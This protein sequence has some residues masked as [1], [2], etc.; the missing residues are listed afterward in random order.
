M[1]DIVK[2]S[3]KFHVN[4]TTYR[5]PALQKI[6]AYSEELSIG[7]PLSPVSDSNSTPLRVQTPNGNTKA[8][9]EYFPIR[10]HLIEDFAGGRFIDSTRDKFIDTFP[11]P[12]NANVYLRGASSGND[13]G[14]SPDFTETRTT[15]GISESGPNTNINYSDSNNRLT[16]TSSSTINAF[17]KIHSQNEYPLIADS[18]GDDEM[19]CVWRR[20]YTG[21]VPSSG[22]VKY[23]IDNGSDSF[24]AELIY[25]NNNIRLRSNGNI[26]R[27]A[28]FRQ[29]FMF[30][31][32]SNRVFLSKTFEPNS[33]EDYIVEGNGGF[34]VFG[35]LQDSSS[36]FIGEMGGTDFSASVTINDLNVNKFSY[37]LVAS[38]RRFQT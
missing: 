9:A 15:G 12:I 23:T 26:F 10:A 5:V 18:F 32:S 8:L 1:G 38:V 16:F 3:L 11:D 37:Q 25:G 22:T 30:D 27:V 36:D 17:V 31:G 28:E 33:E 24:S 20:L 2:N 21:G 19:I 13:F 34:A 29:D 4:G 7:Y 6:P 14:G 35:T